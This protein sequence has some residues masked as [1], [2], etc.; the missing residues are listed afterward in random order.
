MATTVISVP[1]S[2]NKKTIVVLY[3][4]LASHEKQYCNCARVCSKYSLLYTINDKLQMTLWLLQPN[5]LHGQKH[6][7]IWFLAKNVSA[8]FYF[9]KYI[10]YLLHK[11]SMLQLSFY[12]AFYKLHVPLKF[13]FICTLLVVWS[14]TLLD[15]CACIDP[16]V[17][18]LNLWTCLFS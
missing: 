7:E 16:V 18:A 2:M 6:N 13:S 4:K 11:I 3:L 14:F 15:V 9:L 12:V 1:S 10:Q 8:Y 5:R 17:Y